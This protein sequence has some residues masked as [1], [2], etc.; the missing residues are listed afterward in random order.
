VR[1]AGRA[2]DVKQVSFKMGDAL[3]SDRS[4]AKA[5]SVASKDKRSSDTTALQKEHDLTHA[6]LSRLRDTPNQSLHTLQSDV[7]HLTTKLE[8]MLERVEQAQRNIELARATNLGSL[9]NLDGPI[10]MLSKMG[11]RYIYYHADDLTEMLLEDILK[12]TVIELQMIE[13]KMRD[14]VVADEGQQLAQNLL[15]H[16][17]DYQNEESLVQMRIQSEKIDH[18]KLKR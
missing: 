14:S 11:G 16:I 5:S 13:H 12:D 7:A 2:A 6:I 3:E 15:Q 17:V 1:N 18:S 10:G 8:P 9:S 4:K